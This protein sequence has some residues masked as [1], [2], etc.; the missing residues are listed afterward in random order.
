MDS[1][2]FL[3]ISMNILLLY[4]LCC[5][6]KNKWNQFSLR[7][8]WVYFL[9]HQAWILITESWSYW[10]PCA[11]PLHSVNRSSSAIEGPSDSSNH[12]DPPQIPGPLSPHRLPGPK[13]EGFPSSRRRPQSQRSECCQWWMRSASCSRPWS[14]V[15]FGPGAEPKCHWL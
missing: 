11:E 4:F 3:Y 10:W 14:A 2:Y 6:V 9:K 8:F 15:T 12:R 1:L 5:S 13:H 7:R